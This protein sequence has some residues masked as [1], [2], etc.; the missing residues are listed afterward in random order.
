MAFSNNSNR[1]GLSPHAAFFFPREIPSPG[2]KI[3][4][5]FFCF[6]K[7]TEYQLGTHLDDWKKI[8]DRAGS[9][10]LGAKTAKCAAW[11][12]DHQYDS[13]GQRTKFAAGDCAVSHDIARYVRYR[14]YV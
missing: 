6:F 3:D 4:R 13:C 8:A 1:V 14:L 2:V 9:A 12:T 5:I 7:T 10:Q 11:V